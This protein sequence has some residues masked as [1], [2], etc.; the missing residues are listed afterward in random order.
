LG[1]SD[2]YWV[3]RPIANDR[4]SYPAGF[5]PASLNVVMEP[6]IAPTNSY[7]IGP[8]G[9]LTNNNPTIGNFAVKLIQAGGVD[10]TGA[11]TES[12]PTLMKMDALSK[13]SVLNPANNPTGFTFKIA[14]RTGLYTGSFTLADK[15]K[16]KFEG[17]LLQLLNPASNDVFGRGYFLVPPG[18]SPSAGEVKFTIP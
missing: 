18:N 6:W 10:N 16:V 13:V 4:G 7:L 2:F 15:R 1:G 8:L 3:K 5:G 12:L 17:V 14:P 11:N 9:L